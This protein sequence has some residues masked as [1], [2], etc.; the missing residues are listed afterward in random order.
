MLPKGKIIPVPMNCAVLIGEPV[1]WEGHRT[2]FMD[3]L[4]EGLLSLNA[5]APP[6]RWS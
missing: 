2:R 6:L 1:R 4:R 3:S 5:Q